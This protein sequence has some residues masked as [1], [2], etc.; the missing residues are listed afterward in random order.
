M[1]KKTKRLQVPR[2]IAII[3]TR[4]NMVFQPNKGSSFYK[5]PSKNKILP[6]Q[7]NWDSPV[8]TLRLSNHWNYE[9]IH[10]ELVYVTNTN[11]PRGKW[12]LSVNTGTKP[13]PWKVLQIFEVKQGNVIRKIDFNPIQREINSLLVA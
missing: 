8:G 11:V 4:L 10:D 5:R 1:K 7:A 3:V 2:Y 13:K 6:G 12:V 9:N